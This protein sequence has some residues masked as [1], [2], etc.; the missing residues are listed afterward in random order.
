M[1]ESK[2]NFNKEKKLKK[3]KGITRRQFLKFSSL[4]IFFVKFK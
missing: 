3:L 1:L 2:V 4:G